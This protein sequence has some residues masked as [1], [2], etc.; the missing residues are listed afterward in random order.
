ME[1]TIKVFLVCWFL[2]HFE[3]LTEQIERWSFK[4]RDHFNSEIKQLLWDK[5]YDIISCWKCMSL[6]LVFSFTLDPFYAIGASLTA[7]VL[8]KITSK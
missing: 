3:P 4:I 1:I 7:W 8:E 6:W 2:T 5:F